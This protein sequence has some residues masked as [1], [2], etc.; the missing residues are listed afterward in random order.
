MAGIDALRPVALED[1][2]LDGAAALS[3]EA[4]WNQT[5]A[6]WRTM[7]AAGRAL[8]R[9]DRSGRLV[10]SALVLPFGAAFG[11]V[12]MVIVTQSW[13][14][15]GLATALLRECVGLLEDGGRAQMLDATPAG[16]EVYRPLG[17]RDHFPLRRWEGTA[18]GGGAPGKAAARRLTA[19]DLPGLAAHDRAAFGGD[20]RGVLEALISRSGAA[21]RMAADG[22][23]YLLSR[24]GRRARQIGP[25]LADGAGTAAALLADALARVEGPVFIDVPDRHRA[26]TDFLEARGFAPQ[27][28]FMRMYRGAEAGFGDPARMFA[29]AGPE[30][31]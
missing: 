25:I 23:G 5:A 4:G 26:V 12:S 15:K 24:D 30:F 21:G 18:P 27:R 17:F 16:A 3:A 22:A 31:G 28:P 11:F 19:A 14:R 10:A 9:E 2:H 29:V 1:R 8:G 6:D 20:R 7:I 13:R